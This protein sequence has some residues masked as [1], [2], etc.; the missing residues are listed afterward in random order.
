MGP[1]LTMD[2]LDMLMPHMP[3]D[4]DTPTQ[5]LLPTLVL[6]PPLL[7]DPHRVLARDLLSQSMDMVLSQSLDTLMDMA[8][9]HTVLP[10]LTQDMPALSSLSQDSIKPIIY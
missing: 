10:R 5:E 7:P 8:H 2:M 9:H 1:M 3:M 4:T 6:L